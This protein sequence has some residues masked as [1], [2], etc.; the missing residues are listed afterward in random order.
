MLLLAGLKQSFP[1]LKY[2]WV[3]SA[4]RGT[5]VKRA[6]ETLGW[7]VEVVQRP[8]AGYRG[9]WTPPGVEP[10]VGKTGF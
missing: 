2:L 6:K 1:R 9:V 5:F 8:G 10:S 3:D 7:T 4:Y